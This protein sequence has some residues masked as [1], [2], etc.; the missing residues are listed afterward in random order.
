MI[1]HRPKGR[2]FFCSGRGAPARSPGATTQKPPSVTP[3]TV[4]PPRR[5]RYTPSLFAPSLFRPAV[6]PER[7]PSQP[8][9]ACAI[10]RLVRS[11]RRPIERPPAVRP[12]RRPSQPRI[13]CAIRRSSGWCWSILCPIDAPSARRAVRP[14]R[15]LSQ[16]CAA[17]AIRRLVCGARG[18]QAP[19]PRGAQ[20]S[21]GAKSSS[22][23]AVIWMKAP[24]RRA[25]RPVRQP[26]ITRAACAIHRR[27]SFGAGVNHQP[28]ESSAPGPIKNDDSRTR[29]NPKGG[30]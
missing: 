7:R 29:E 15:R 26:S 16:P 4:R 13:A 24:P 27:E 10:R 5:L 25:V 18:G 21:N 14:T 6:R 3:A 19:P 9:V 22:N 11:I 28:S 30:F 2:F 17:C 8:C 20:S 1:P 12:T 23:G